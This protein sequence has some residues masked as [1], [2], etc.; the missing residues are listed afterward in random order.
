MVD[1]DIIIKDATIVDGTGWKA[2]K[3]SI[4]V[5][6]DRITA[7]GEVG[8]DA[9][10]V[11]DAKGL[12][13]M[14]GFIDA[15]SHSDMSLLFYQKCESCVMQGVT[16]FVGGQCGTSPAPIGGATTLFGPAADY[17]TEIEPHKYYPANGLYLL[18]EVNKLLKEKFGWV[19][20]WHT[21][22]EYFKRV[23]TEGISINYA[24]LLGHGTC[25]Y[26]IMGKNFKRTATDSEIEEMS[27]LV[28]KGME[29]GCRGMSTGLDYDP[30]VFADEKELETHLR[31]VKE[32]GGIYSP[33]WR[34][35]GRRRE[36]A[37]WHRAIE[38]ITGIREVIEMSKKVGIRLQI[39]HL[40][41]GYY[42]MPPP[43]P[44]IQ[45][46]IGKAT[47]SL[48]DEAKREGLEVTFDVIPYREEGETLPY[49]CSILTPWIRE[50]GS[51]ENLA[52]WLK[53]DDYRR[54]IKETLYTGKWFIKANQNPLTNPRWAENIKVVKSKNPSYENRTI[55]QIA[56]DQNKD[57]IDAWF[58]IIVEDPDTRGAIPDYRGTD[59]YVKLFFKNPLGMVGVDKSAVDLKREQ[60]T[61]PYT[62][63][64]VNSYSAFPSFLNRYVKE[65]RIFT[66]EEAAIKTS[67][68][69]AKAY[70]FKGRGLLK[71]G[72]IADIVLIDWPKLEVV[73]DVIKPRRYP[74]GIEY[75]FV[76]GKAV[77]E[78]AKHTGAKPGKILTRE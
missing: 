41:S 21:M 67:A 4:G 64:G 28:Y 32:Y 14:P 12:T 3:G 38:P 7:I 5:Y 45:E 1:Y 61:P 66:I 68:L 58:D 18:D 77:V 33:H 34:R 36:R 27:E 30:D 76:N 55:A 47:L 22:G 75:V 52:K 49:L 2:Y 59:E 65:Q 20:D 50:T 24:P 72:Y 35:T 74:K 69:A 31:I 46:A 51:R 11:V 43:P 6:G 16:T 78:E 71:D 26:V 39:A 70:E 73:G 54:E 42:V 15:H 53:A 40:Y 62:I 37:K 19:I 44:I 29:D 25:R 8:G 9:K 63:P 60:K 48:I 56:G 23:E 10:K 17:I 57:S 13:A